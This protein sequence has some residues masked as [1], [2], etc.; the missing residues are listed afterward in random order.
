M[1]GTQLKSIEREKDLGVTVSN[2]LKPSQQCSEVVK[3]ANE[4]IGFVGRSFEHKSKEVILTL[5]NLLV[6]PHL[7][8][9]VQAR[10]PYYKKDINKLERVQRRVTKMIPSLREKSYKECL[11]ELNLFPLT[12]CR[13][14][15][16]LIQVFKIMKTIDNMGCDKYF[17]VDRLN[18]TRGHGYKRVRKHVNSHEAMNFFFN[19]VISTWN[20]LSLLWAKRLI[21]G[22]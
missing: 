13:L 3:K 19:R 16:D 4:I 5:Y 20:G 14:R 12:Q 1:N 21:D 22:I 8:Y 7:E 9:C 10:S 15:G 18:Y 6:Q 17:T 11:K 2:D